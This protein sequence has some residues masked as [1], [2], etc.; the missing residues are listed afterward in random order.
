VDISLEVFPSIDQ[1]AETEKPVEAA[2]APVPAPLKEMPAD[3]Y[4]KKVLDSIKTFFRNRSKNQEK[5]GFTADGNLEIKEPAGTIQLKRFVPLDPSE[6]ATLEEFRL[7]T[8]AD[9]E[10]KYE[11]ERLVLAAAWEQYHS[12]GGMRPVLAA[13]QR[14]AELDAR[15]SAIR[16]AVRNIMP[17]SNPRTS[18]I[19]LSE[20]YEERKL[21]QSSYFG[22]LKE[23][24]QQFGQDLDKMRSEEPFDKELYR[25]AFYEFNP[26]H[27][28]GKYVADSAA[29]A[30]E[31][32]VAEGPSE[33][34]YRQNLKDGRKARIFFET[35]STVNG[36]LS[37]MWPVEFTMDDTRYFT[38]LQAYEA[39]RAKELKMDELRTSILKTRSARTI[40]LMTRKVVGHPA[41][42]KG[43]W[44]KI[45][46]Q[47]YQQTETLKEKLLATGTDALVYADVREGPSGI[48]LADKDSGALDPSKWK[49]ENAVGLA[50]ETIRTR[51][52]EGGLEEAPVNDAPKESVISEEEQAKAKVGAIIN[53]R[54]FNGK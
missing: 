23:R 50:Q 34:T 8:L 53:A 29:P 7:D 35:D 5:Y 9:L 2:P 37:P 4:E 18:D 20:R 16:A 11:A 42:A 44:L 51:M 40:R 48:G 1:M 26:E 47:I 21:L 28:Q 43:L 52:R 38:A 3:P 27:D 41:D 13:N 15:R 36:F 54:R 22:K 49:G 33:I 45:F 24:Q 46:T 25:M 12:T 19:I 6:R 14:M 17:I 30:K 31:E 32:D 10:V 39:E